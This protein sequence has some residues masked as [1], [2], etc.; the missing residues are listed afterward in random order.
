MG[1]GANRTRTLSI[2]TMFSLM[3]VVSE[4]STWYRGV[5]SRVRP[6]C[7]VFT[8]GTDDARVCTLIERQL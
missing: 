6:V 5:P 4:Q 2:T 3:V 1:L 7:G 8:V